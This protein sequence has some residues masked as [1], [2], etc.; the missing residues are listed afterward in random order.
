MKADSL[1]VFRDLII[2][3]LISDDVQNAVGVCILLG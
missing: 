1:I 2:L 3:I